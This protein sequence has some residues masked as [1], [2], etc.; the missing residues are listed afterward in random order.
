MKH[1]LNKHIKYVRIVRHSEFVRIPR[2]KIRIGLTEGKLELPF[3]LFH[4]HFPQFMT[5]FKTPK[6]LTGYFDNLSG[7]VHRFLVGFLKSVSRHPC[8]LGFIV[9]YI[10]NPTYN[11]C[12]LL[13]SRNII[14]LIKIT[15]L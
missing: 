8:I 11:E 5:Q 13:I 14:L 1:L 6:P 4:S 9:V 7:A 10:Q 15:T 3:L 12:Y 2:M